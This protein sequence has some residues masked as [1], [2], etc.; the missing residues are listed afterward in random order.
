[1]TLEAFLKKYKQHEVDFLLPKSKGDNHVY[2]DLFF[3]YSSPEQRWQEVHAL[4]QQYLNFYLKKYK[5]KKVTEEELLL[6]L[7]FPEVPYVALG[8]CKNGIYG[9]GSGDDRAYIFKDYIFDNEDVKKVGIEALAGLSISIGGIGPD[10]LSDMVANFAMLRLL[11]YTN[12]QVAL[13]SI[14]TREFQIGRVLNVG[15]FEWEP[16]T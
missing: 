3:L 9:R 6:K 5:D 12:E 11:E 2:L 13:Y 10:L 14:E 7:H 4:I 1:M 8:H 16:P 15:S